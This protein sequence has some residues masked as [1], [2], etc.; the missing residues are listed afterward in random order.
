MKRLASN[1]FYPVFSVAALNVAVRYESVTRTLPN[2]VEFEAI[3]WGF[4]DLL[5][6][7]VNALLPIWLHET[8]TIAVQ[9]SI[10]D[11]G[12]TNESILRGIM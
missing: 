3:L 2:K 1:D 11:I 7:R 6:N 12:A 10:K 4:D 8:C 9:A 5:T